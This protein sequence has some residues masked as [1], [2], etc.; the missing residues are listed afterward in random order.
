MS[1]AIIDGGEEGRYERDFE[2][3]GL[4]L[5]EE[6]L[7]GIG[8]VWVIG[9][10]GEELIFLFEGHGTGE[11]EGIEFGVEGDGFLDIL[12]DFEIFRRVEELDGGFLS[13]LE[14]LSEVD[15]ERG[16]LDFFHFLEIWLGGGV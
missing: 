2:L 6:I 15:D 7:D 16:V 14:R 10:E 11:S 13:E 12:R 8:V 1:K 9:S 3:V 4:G 5:L